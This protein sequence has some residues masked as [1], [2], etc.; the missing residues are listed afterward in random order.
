MQSL[1]DYAVF[2]RVHPILMLLTDV[3][4]LLTYARS[5]KKKRF[6]RE[7]AVL[8]DVN[9]RLLQ[10]MKIR[11]MFAKSMTKILLLHWLPCLTLVT[12]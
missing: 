3:V 10:M 11:R 5:R 9:A 4:P 7:A 12:G 8:F 2:A 6:V 1:I